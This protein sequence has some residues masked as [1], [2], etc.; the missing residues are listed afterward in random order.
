MRRLGC[1]HRALLAQLQ[2]SQLKASRAEQLQ[3]IKT[4]ASV[5]NQT[6]PEHKSQQTWSSHLL[7]LGLGF[8][9][10]AGAFAAYG[11][12]YCEQQ[13][14]SVCIVTALSMVTKSSER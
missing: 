11:V 10:A 13:A 14:S 8:G 5:T 3:H 1:L 4:L 2:H 7:K 6:G 9:A 12:S